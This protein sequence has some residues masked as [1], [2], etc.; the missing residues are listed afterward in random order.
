[1]GRAWIAL[2]SWLVQA[3]AGG[4]VSPG[5]CPLAGRGLACCGRHLF[6]AAFIAVAAEAER[7]VLLV[8]QPPTGVR[9]RS[10]QLPASLL[11]SLRGQRS[12]QPTTAEGRVRA[13]EAGRPQ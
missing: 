1:M 12:W 4:R 13:A 3:F 8:S 5:G 6:A 10:G 9:A 11:A 2:R 7:L